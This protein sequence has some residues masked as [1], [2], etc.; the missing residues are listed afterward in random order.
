MDQLGSVS[1]ITNNLGERAERRNYHPFG[2]ISWDDTLDA[3]LTTETKGFVGERYDADAGLQ[4][5][6]ARYYD[7]ELALFIQPDWFPVTDAGV[8]TNR[9]AYSFNDPVNK[10][11]PNGNASGPDDGS[12]PNTGPNDK[13]A[14]DNATQ[15]GLG[16]SE[17]SE[18]AVTMAVGLTGIPAVVATG[19]AVIEGNIAGIAVGAADIYTLSFAVLSFYL[20]AFALA[21]GPFATG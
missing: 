6:N 3:T 19:Q 13:S 21:F 18:K 1:G 5:L 11:D 8:G 12:R 16:P 20:C 9:Y 17:G 7:P 2:E 15:H 14:Q 4:Y 10:F